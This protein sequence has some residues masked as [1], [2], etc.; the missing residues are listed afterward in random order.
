MLEHLIVAIQ[1]ESN[2]KA[3]APPKAHLGVY[4]PNVVNFPNNVQYKLDYTQG[5]RGGSKTPGA[6]NTKQN[7][8]GGGAKT[9][10]SK[11]S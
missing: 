6:I 1:N 10:K 8:V 7:V 3:A 2:G 5:F 4:S 9:S 11:E